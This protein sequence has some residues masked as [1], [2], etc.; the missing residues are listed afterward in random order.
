VDL[1]GEDGALTRLWVAKATRAVLK[2]VST[3]P[4][5]NGA[6]MTAVLQP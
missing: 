3:S 6:T 4:Q 1:A 2:S 5:L